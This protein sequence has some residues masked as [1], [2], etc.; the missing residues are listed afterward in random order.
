MRQEESKEVPLRLAI[1]VT[2]AVTQRAGVGRYTRDLVRSLAALPD[3]PDLRPFYAAPHAPYPLDCGPAA[4]AI[5]RGI[6]SFRFELLAR[7]LVRWPAHGPWDGADVYHATDIVYP[8]VRA[9]AVVSTVHDLSFAI[10]PEFHTRLNGGYLRAATPIV[11]RRASLVIADSVST[12]RDLVDRT[13]LPERK[14]RVVYPGTSDVFRLAVDPG[15]RQRVRQHYGLPASFI[16]SVGTLE[17]R[18]NLARTLR[19]YT[20]LREKLP[21]APPLALVGG[22]GW[23]LDQATLAGTV[24]AASIRRL[25][26][27]PDGDLAALYASCSAFVYPSLYEGWGLPVAEAMTL[28]APTVTSTVSSMPE[29]AGD[30]ALLVDPRSE[31]QIALALERVLTDSALA[32]R[33]RRDGPPQAA[34]FSCERWARATLDVYREAA[35]T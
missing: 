33:L 22:T 24:D 30:A 1:D 11:T 29:V 25:G 32:A 3:G 35:G 28:G 17:P 26:Y 10:F 9:M 14:I 21:D 15:E 8:P 7:H 18:K 5:R 6:R 16:L 19:A 23:R 4:I 34:Q 13:G 2:A 20:L 27:V 31:E 12:K